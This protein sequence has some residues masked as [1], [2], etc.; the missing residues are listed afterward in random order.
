MIYQKTYV[1][2]RKGQPGSAQIWNALK[3][4]KF[5]NQ[6]ILSVTVLQRTGQHVRWRAGGRSGSSENGDLSFFRRK[7]QHPQGRHRGR[8]STTIYVALPAYSV[9][10]DIRFKRCK[11]AVIK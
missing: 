3:E 9:P 1:N 10:V 2:D 4:T 6:A 11:V 8:R 5:A 7:P